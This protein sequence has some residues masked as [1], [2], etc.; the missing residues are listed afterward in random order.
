MWTQRGT[1][2]GE[3][4]DLLVAAMRWRGHYHRFDQSRVVGWRDYF[5]PINAQIF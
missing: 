1:Q 4:H 5:G 2:S 3:G